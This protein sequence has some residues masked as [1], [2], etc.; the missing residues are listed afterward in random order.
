[1]PLLAALNSGGFLYVSHIHVWRLLRR[2][3]LYT[4]GA[5]EPRMLA[6]LLRMLVVERLAM[7]SVWR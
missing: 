3:R 2:I 6:H 5:H 7:A 1:M 4:K